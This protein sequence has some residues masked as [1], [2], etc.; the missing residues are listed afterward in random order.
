MV[1][2]FPCTD[3]PSLSR[4]LTLSSGWS[5][6]LSFCRKN[7]LLSLWCHIL[8]RKLCN[9]ITVAGTQQE[10]AGVGAQPTIHGV[11]CSTHHTSLWYHL[12]DSWEL[13]TCALLWILKLPKG[14]S[15]QYV[16]PIDR[17]GEPLRSWAE[18]EEVRSLGYGTVV[19]PCVFPCS[20]PQA[21]NSHHDALCCW[22][23]CEHELN[24]RNPEHRWTL[25]HFRLIIASILSEQQRGDSHSTSQFMA[26]LFK[27][28]PAAPWWGL[29]VCV[30]PSSYVA[31]LTQNVIAS[32]GR[33][34]GSHK[35]MRLSL[36]SFM[37]KVSI[38]RKE[39]PE[40]ESPR[41][42]TRGTQEDRSFPLPEMR[43]GPPMCWLGTAGP[44]SPSSYVFVCCCQPRLD[45]RT[46]LKHH[47][48]PCQG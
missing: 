25:L 34:L 45:S 35:V 46:D 37:N 36:W 13:V 44:H 15:C 38:L 18:W 26:F 17:R 21:V 29:A 4:D 47:V 30:S 42:W 8:S 27:N 6:A 1:R 23:S 20:W 22:R 7:S 31:I 32:E 28:F 40:R 5:L 43:S 24:P 2:I 48:T 33:S 12:A 41:Q 16:V 9:I 11:V 39:L 10:Q 14:L 19:H 3:A